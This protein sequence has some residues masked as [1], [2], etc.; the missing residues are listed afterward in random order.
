MHLFFLSILLLISPL[1][2]QDFSRSINITGTK[3]IVLNNN[4]FIIQD[5]TNSIYEEDNPCMNYYERI[6]IMYT[7]FDVEIAM[8]I[9]FQ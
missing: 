3:K 2:S 4:T 1:Y 5:F 8:R 7:H 6:E 9:T